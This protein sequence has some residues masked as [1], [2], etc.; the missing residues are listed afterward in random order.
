MRVVFI[1]LHGNVF[2]TR[3]A[4]QYI[5][6]KSSAPKHRYILN[7]MIDNGYEVCNYVNNSG[8]T[9]C[10]LDTVVNGI[11]NSKVKKLMSKFRFFEYKIVMF[12]NEIDSK[13][14]TLIKTANEI[15]EDDIVLTYTHFKEQ[16]ECMRVLSGT[17]VVSLLHF[18]G[19][20]EISSLLEKSNVK[21]FYAEANLSKYSV[22]FKK[23]F[24]WFNGEFFILPFVFNKRFEIKTNFQKRKKKAV[25]I[26]TVTKYE[27]DE[28]VETYGSSCY[29]PLRKQ[30]LDKK[31]KLV[32]YLDCEIYEYEEEDLKVPDSNDGSLTKAYKKIYNAFHTGRQKK[33]FS[34]D[35]VEKFNEYQMCIVPE[36][37][38][39]M[40]GIGFV[41]GM[42]CGCAY[43]GLNYDAYK[44]LGL[45]EGI[46]FIGYDG[47][48][49][50]LIKKIRY[51][52]DEA[53]FKEL[54]SIASAGCSFVRDNFNSETV[55]KNFIERL[56]SIGKSN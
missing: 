21:Y 7:Y 47:T 17:K 33:Y 14:I 46:H 8:F 2:Y 9:L 43:I 31:N 26:G 42:A 48:I 10:G 24:K 41:E 52:Q 49:D 32:P 29:Q 11:G 15:K 55:A 54:E 6:K 1:N 39:G 56:L 25:A 23:N 44:D 37:V 22:L 38:Q 50:D 27:N 5:T 12:L 34:F 4:W 20:S 35:M 40:P 28:F 18:Y 16:I 30:I 19:D 45:I 51:Y 53:H 3:T 36:D 13:K